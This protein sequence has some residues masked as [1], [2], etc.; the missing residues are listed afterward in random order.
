MHEVVDRTALRAW[1][2]HI[3]RG[4]VGQS[5]S[6]PMRRSSRLPHCC[7][8][9]RIGQRQI[10]GRLFERDLSHVRRIDRHPAK[11]SQV[12][13]GAAVLRARVALVDDEAEALR[14]QRGSARRATRRR[15]R[16]GMP[17]RAA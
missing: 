12:N 3:V 2:R 10:A 6:F 5:S 14:V 11:P 16:A 17:G 13:L 8:T 15:S 1:Q 9:C 4:V 7:G